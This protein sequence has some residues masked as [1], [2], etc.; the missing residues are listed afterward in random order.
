MGQGWVCGAQKNWVA[1]VNAVKGKGYNDQNLQKFR[2]T[3]ISHIRDS[4]WIRTAQGRIK[5]DVE[6]SQMP[7]S[8]VKC[9]HCKYL[10]MAFNMIR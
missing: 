7:A 5:D 6:V 8:E 10:A 3:L 9:G 2:M 4:Q 1:G